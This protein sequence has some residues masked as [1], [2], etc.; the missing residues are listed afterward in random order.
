MGILQHVSATYVAIF[1]EF[2]VASRTV[3]IAA[4]L[5]EWCLAACTYCVHHPKYHGTLYSNCLSLR[6]VI[7]IIII[8]I[9][10]TIIMY[11]NLVVTRWQ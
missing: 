6:F 1:R 4:I 3:Y 11:C 7:I 9:I 5:L 10:I 8:I 2:G